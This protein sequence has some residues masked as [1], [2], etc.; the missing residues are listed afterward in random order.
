MRT[1][2]SILYFNIRPEINEKLSLGLLMVYGDN[3]QFHYSKSKLSTIK[4]LVSNS[5]Y[6]AAFNYLKYINK[7]VSTNE[8]ANNK[9]EILDLPSDNK[10]TRIFS[11]SYLE[12]LSRYNNNLLSFSAPKILE[13]EASNKI[14]VKLFSKLIDENGFARIEKPE[15]E[16][17]AFK[18]KYF[19][20]IKSYYSI[21]KS[22]DSTNYEKLVT[23][24]KLDLLGKNEKE[25]FGQSVDFENQVNTLEHTISK[26]MHLHY[27]LPEAQQFIIGSEPQKNQ[28]VNHRIWSNVRSN[29][30]FE[31]VDISEADK[32]EEYA[33][34][35]GVLPLFQK[36]ID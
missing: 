13:I 8:L 24:I 28:I 25:V 23:P 7:S 32:I 2:Y 22:I 19:P 5:I 14:F 1:F 36:E 9:D 29:N 17:V 18:K 6:R 27:A 26:L 10:Y 30:V 20:K 11:E 16:I 31:Y 35:H 21:E 4:N 3:I 34:E 33:K 15:K 12:Y